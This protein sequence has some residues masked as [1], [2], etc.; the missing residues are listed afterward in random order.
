MA[1]LQ[2]SLRWG[3]S[4]ALPFGLGCFAA[5]L[6]RESVLQRSGGGTALLLLLSSIDEPNVL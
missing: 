5:E 1:V 2:Q 3:C 6:R 4:A